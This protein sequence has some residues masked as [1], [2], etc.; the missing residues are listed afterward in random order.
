MDEDF[1]RSKH[2]SYKDRNGVQEYLDFLIMRQE[3]EK[4]Q[5]ENQGNAH[6]LTHYEALLRRCQNPRLPFGS[7]QTFHDVSV[8]YGDIVHTSVVERKVKFR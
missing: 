7:Y 8:C 1:K 2:F 3:Q 5:T 4:G 6:A